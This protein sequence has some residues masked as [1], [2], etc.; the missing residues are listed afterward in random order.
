MRAETLGIAVSFI[1][2]YSVFFLDGQHLMN[3]KDCPAMAAHIS[4]HVREAFSAGMAESSRA[5]G[6]ILFFA[7][8]LAI[9]CLRP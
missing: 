5:I 3:V 4:A 1:S 8:L 6:I 7:F 2:M 9:K